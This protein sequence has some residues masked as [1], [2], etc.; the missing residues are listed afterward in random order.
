MP[1]FTHRWGKSCTFITCSGTPMNWKSS[2]PCAINELIAHGKSKA[3]RKFS[4]FFRDLG[5]QG[6]RA[7]LPE[8]TLLN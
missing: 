7:E 1:G 4:G 8:E 3:R 2:L 5:A 6:M